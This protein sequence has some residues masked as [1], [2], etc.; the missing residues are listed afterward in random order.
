MTW[1]SLPKY[2]EA[3]SDGVIDFVRNAL[4]NFGQGDEI[5]CPCKDCSNRFWFSQEDVYDH[6]V[7]NGP[8]P[9]FANWIFEV[10]TVKFRK[11][12]D[13]TDCEMGMGLG[14]IFDEMIHNEGK[15][16][17]G[18]NKAAKEFY[19]VVEEG[20]Q[21]LYVGSEK[22]TRLGFIVRL[23]LLKCSHGFTESAFSGI[24]ELIKEAFPDVNLPPSFRAA[25]NMIRD[26]DSS[27]PPLSGMD[28]EELLHGFLS[29]KC[30]TKTNENKSVGYAIGS[31]RNKDGITVELADKVWVNAHR[32]V[33]FNCGNVEIEKLIEDHRTLFESHGKSKKYEREKTHTQEFHNWLNDEVGKRSESSLELLHLARGPQRAAKK[34]SGYVVNGFRFHTKKRDAKCT[35][36]NSGVILT[37]LTISFASSKDKNPTVGDVTYYGAIE[38]II[39]VD[40]WGAFTKLPRENNDKGEGSDVLE[41]VCGPTMQDIEL[42]FELQNQ[43]TDDNCWCRDD[44]PSAQCLVSYSGSE[45]ENDELCE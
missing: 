18:M 36:Q 16:R 8:C 9:T 34:F 30:K 11:T 17:T 2:S 7:F 33:L 38:E 23:Y 42:D 32:Y 25:K 21:P 27:P 6:L 22:F 40:Y 13:R 20:K 5:R 43:L 14:E 37:A 41:D 39:E 1:V 29:A 45:E 15:V 26:L 28:I 19:K 12:N 24:L 3:Y 35:T 4:D 44:I 31:R 10:S